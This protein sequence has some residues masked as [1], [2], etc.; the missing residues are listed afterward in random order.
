MLYRYDRS[1]EIRAI[2]VIDLVALT[3]GAYLRL[4][5]YL[6]DV[7]LVQR[8]RWNFAPTN[9]PL[10]WALVEPQVRKVKKVSDFLWVRVLDV[11]TAL[12]ARPWGADGSVVLE[13]DDP[14]GHAAGRWQVRVE[15]GRASVERT[16]AAA[17]V[18]LAADTLGSL[19]LG[20]VTVPTLRV[21]GRLA[22]DGDAMATFAAMA[23]AGPTPYCITGF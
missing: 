7:D 4:W 22:G 20:G 17:D 3:P 5:Q 9:D 8:V 21:G 6:A 19:Y 16:E 10:E 15:D 18:R 23:D 12:A 1:G 2:D 14:L 13:V 11:P